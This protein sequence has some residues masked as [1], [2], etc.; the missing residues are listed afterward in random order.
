MWFQFLLILYLTDLYSFFVVRKKLIYGYFIFTSSGN[1]ISWLV[2]EAT[3]MCEQR[4]FVV[5]QFIKND[6]SVIG[7]RRF[8]KEKILIKAPWKSPRDLVYG[9]VPDVWNLNFETNSPQNEKFVNFPGVW[10]V[11]TNFIMYFSN[12]CDLRRCSL[13]R[14]LI[15]QTSGTYL[16]I[17]Q[18]GPAKTP[19]MGEKL[20][21]VR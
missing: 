16:F 13:E 3:R 10:N 14:A 20:S 12:F 6:E 5:E 2:T 21:R 15:F 4:S 17:D 1:S 7:T 18:V 19:L 8:L 11:C 9:K